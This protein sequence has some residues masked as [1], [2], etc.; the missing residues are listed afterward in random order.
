MHLAE[1][2]ILVTLRIE[3]TRAATIAISA[4]SQS[5]VRLN[6]NGKTSSETVQVPR[7]S[8]IRLLADF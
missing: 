5:P 6:V 7:Q 3:K 1:P 4:A 2:S 8:F